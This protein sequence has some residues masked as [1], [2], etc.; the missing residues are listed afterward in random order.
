WEAHKMEPARNANEFQFVIF[1]IQD[2]INYYV[3]AGGIRS[4]EFALEVADLPFVK[5]IDLVLNFPAHTR[6]ASKKIENGGEIAA[7][8]GTVVEVIAKLSAQ[9]K[10]AR[11]VL[12]DGTKI[13]MSASGENQ[14]AGHL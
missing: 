2:S 3:E 5:Q 11:I 8:K 12:G 10:S 13:E 1:N 9:A 4:Q 7:L 14:F 6:M